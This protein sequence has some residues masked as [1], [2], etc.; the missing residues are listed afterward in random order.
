[1]LS[2]HTPE[3]AADPPLPVI[4]GLEG[5]VANEDFGPRLA[6]LVHDLCGLRADDRILDVGS[7][8]G[9][10]ARPL[11]QYL[12]PDGSYDGLDIVSEAVAWCTEHITSVHPNF[13]F[14]HA[15]VHNDRYNPTG[16]LQDSEYELPYDDASFDVVV[17]TSVFTHML[18]AGV[19]QYVSQIARVLRPGGH[20]LITM[21]LLNPESDRLR[22]LPASTFAF[23]HDR[24]VHSIQRIDPPEAAVAYREDF[25]RDLF[26]TNGLDP[27]IHYGSW[28][29]RP[30]FLDLQ[31]V[32]VSSRADSR[33]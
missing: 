28:C 18:P 3:G 21:F 6:G 31:D 23:P 20:A 30:D 19:S 33:A 7:G 22:K 26:H 9:R 25:V 15:P 1:M 2:M 10:V 12:G 32:L 17:L 4:A 24:G 11:A 5:L 14:R 8:I 13:R 29:G 16:V 27:Q